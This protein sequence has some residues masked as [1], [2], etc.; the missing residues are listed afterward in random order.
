MNRFAL[1]LVALMLAGCNQAA[2]APAPP[3]N[4]PAP[5]APAATPVATEARRA[6]ATGVV[7][8]VDAAAHTVTIAHGPV[9]ALGWPGM[10][11]TFQA[12]DA[13][14]SAIKAGDNVAFEFTSTGMDGKIVSITRQ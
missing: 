14:F 7:E 2:Q 6:S 9:D 13:D 3:A 8:S 11:M 12:P 4:T 5:P 10:T 1:V